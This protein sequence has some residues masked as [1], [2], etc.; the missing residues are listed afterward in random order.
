MAEWLQRAVVVRVVSDSSP[1][2]GEHKNLSGRREPSDYVSFRRAFE[3]QW[4][5]TLNT[6]DTKPSTT[7]HNTPYKVELYISPFPPDVANL[8]PRE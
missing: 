8:F 6:H 7:Q 1:G 4:I 2:R 3:R 5:H